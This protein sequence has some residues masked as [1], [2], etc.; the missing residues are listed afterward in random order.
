MKAEVSFLNLAKNNNNNEKP[1][2]DLAAAG[3]KKIA[4]LEMKDHEKL[5]QKMVSFFVYQCFEV[6]PA[7]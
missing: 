7:F 5:G 6:T 1:N 2:V 3:G 4:P